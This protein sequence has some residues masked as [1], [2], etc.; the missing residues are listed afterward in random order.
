MN[1]SDAKKL[2]SHVPFLSVAEVLNSV[3][4]DW[5][6]IGG[7]AANVYRAEE[8]QTVDY[9]FYVRSLEGLEA[10]LVSH[11]FT[12]TRT[13]KANGSPDQLLQIR[14]S[15]DG[16]QFD[17]NLADFEYQFDV[18]ER[19]RSNGNINTV[20]DVIIQKLIAWRPRDRDDIE[21][22]LRT[23]PKLDTDYI[24]RWAGEFDRTDQWEIA[25]RGMLA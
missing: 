8:R 20:E 6:A 4:T 9:D 15:R 14:A 2:R 10:A 3:G 16:D 25:K 21:S 7:R 22:I 19:A 13:Y 18:I 24:E 12:I 17:F 11:G 5:A 23:R 1:N